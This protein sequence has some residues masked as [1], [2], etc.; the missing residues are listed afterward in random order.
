MDGVERK[1]LL[2]FVVVLIAKIKFGGVPVF[3]SRY[4]GEWFR[5]EM[6]LCYRK[7]WNNRVVC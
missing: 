2:N 5:L 7:N 6:L 3:R 1:L 4:G